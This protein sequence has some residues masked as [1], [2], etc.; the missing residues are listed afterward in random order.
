MEEEYWLKFGFKE[1]GD[2]TC[3]RTISE[4][5]PTEKFS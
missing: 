4:S 3:I 2:L 1:N 5:K